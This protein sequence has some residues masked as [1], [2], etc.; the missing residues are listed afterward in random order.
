M[1]K[2]GPRKEPTIIKIAKGNPGKRPLNKNEPKPPSDDITPPEW[3]TGV[4]REKWENVVPKL[5]GMGVMTNADVDTIARYCTM[6]EQYVKYLE[7]CRR[8]LD[9]LV[10]RDDA[11]KV[12]Y[13]QSTPAATMMTKLAASMLRIEQEFGLTPSARS[14]LSVGTQAPKDDLEAF[15]AAEGA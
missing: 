12:K 4:A 14:G 5:I 3:V 10:I 1:G 2:R 11:G 15:F 7:Q 9:V 6:H 13:M 8:G